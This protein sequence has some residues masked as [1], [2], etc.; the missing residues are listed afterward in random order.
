MTDNTSQIIFD[1]KI[2]SADDPVVSAVSRGLMYGDGVFE[3]LRTYSGQTLFLQ[4]H[5]ERL[6]SGCEILGIAPNEQLDLTQLKK[7]LHQLLQK[8]SLLDR[9]GIVRIQVWRNGKRGYQ[10]DQEAST[11]LSITVSSCPDVFSYPKLATVSTRRIPSNSLPSSAKFTNGINYILAA[12]EAVQKG[13]DDALMQTIRGWVSETTI[14]NVFW[15][16]DRTIF[17]PSVDCDLI[18]GITRNI[19]L[20]IIDNLDL[21]VE[22][23]QFELNQILD[24]DS[25]WICNSIREVLPVKQ[26]NDYSFNT[27]NELLRSLQKH[28]LDFRNANLEKLDF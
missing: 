16:K 23:G 5:L 13:A 27:D 26:L 21:K 25:V 15:A 12:R 19:L 8:N 4:K 11:H 14:A 20:G 28:F 10:P 9:D 1:G 24:A 2:I 18:P 7:Y 6:L 22:Q 3:T 17:T